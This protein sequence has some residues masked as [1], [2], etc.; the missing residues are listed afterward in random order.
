MMWIW[1]VSVFSGNT[2]IL[3]KSRSTSDLYQWRAFRKPKTHTNKIQT[4]AVPQP[5][6]WC[7]QRKHH[8]IPF[9]VVL[10]QSF[11][12][13]LLCVFRPVQLHLQFIVSLS[14]KWGSFM[15]MQKK[16]KTF[17]FIQLRGKYLEHIFGVQRSC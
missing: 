4:T 3:F 6:L 15:K 7:K 11:R 9:S 1:L 2:H 10:T 16:R 17:L 13:T 8:L 5:Y 12:K 14:W